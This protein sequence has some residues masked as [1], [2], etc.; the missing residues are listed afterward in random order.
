MFHPVP[1]SHLVVIFFVP[2]QGM[3]AC[4]YYIHARSGVQILGF[5]PHHLLRGYH[6]G[7]AYSWLFGWH[8][9][10]THLQ[11]VVLPFPMQFLGQITCY[12][13][14]GQGEMTICNLQVRWRHQL[15][16]EGV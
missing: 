10:W 1:P 4:D 9:D 2:P 5:Y 7:V 8:D 6:W 11:K 15:Y 13:Y 16:A 3:W 14:H 12:V